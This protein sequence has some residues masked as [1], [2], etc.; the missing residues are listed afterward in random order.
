MSD[1]VEK[2]N[3]VVDVRSMSQLSEF[4]VVLQKFIV[5]NKLFT[6]IRERAYVHVEGWEFAG[7]ATGISPMIRL[8]EDLSD[9]KE[10]KYK[11]QVDLV[12][13]EDRVVGFGMAICS[14]KEK[15]KAGFD[16]YAIASMAQ[17]RAIGKAYRN[18]LAFLM[19]MAGYEPTP[20][21]EITV[22]AVKVSD[23]SK[24]E[25]DKPATTN[26]KEAILNLMKKSGKDI[27][28]EENL[29]KGEAIGLMNELS[30]GAE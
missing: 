4:A 18:K 8:V 20:A 5:K 28:I 22:D 17:T 6:E 25:L 11:C 19:K 29:T 27:K 14:N 9:E 23:L 15:S 24:E 2:K 12:N 13:R 16:E 26:Q 30:G 7:L 21:E 1:V 3:E 10:I